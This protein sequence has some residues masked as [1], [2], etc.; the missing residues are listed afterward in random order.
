[1]HRFLKPVLAG[2]TL[3]TLAVPALASAQSYADGRGYYADRG[4]YSRSYRHDR[5]GRDYGYRDF[6]H[7]D[8]WRHHN[9]ERPHG[10]YDGRWR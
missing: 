2:A 9:Y 4:D 8:S 5:W 3:L 1:M 10:G 6:G 7:R